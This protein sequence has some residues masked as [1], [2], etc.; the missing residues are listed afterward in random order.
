MLIARAPVRLSFAGGGTDLPAYYLKHGG[1]VVST[2]LDK[3]FYVF[4]NV[5]GDDTI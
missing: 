5:S 4:L 2:T 3:Y 1:A